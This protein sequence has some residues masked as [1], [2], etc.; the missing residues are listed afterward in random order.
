[1]TRPAMFS[2]SSPE[3]PKMAPSQ[4]SFLQNSGMFHS[5]KN[6]C[7]YSSLEADMFIMYD[8]SQIA[9]VRFSKSGSRTRMTWKRFAQKAAI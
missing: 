2:Y 9:A 3:S 6:S 7:M 5:S 1:M 4:A 8:I